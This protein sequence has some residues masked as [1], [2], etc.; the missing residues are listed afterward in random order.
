M[1]RSL[2]LERILTPGSSSLLV[3]AKESQE[4]EDSVTRSYLE[5][6][7]VPVVLVA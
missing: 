5:S 3:L 7:A 1:N 6:L 4:L 2:L